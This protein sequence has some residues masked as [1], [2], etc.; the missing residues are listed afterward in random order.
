MTDRPAEPSRILIVRLSALGDLVFCTSLLDGLR[1]RF[2]DAHIAWLAQSGFAGVLHEDPRV[3]EVIAIPKD[4]LS[5]PSALLRLRHRL[6]ARRYDWVIDAQGLAK[7]RLLASLAGGHRI[8][9]RSK[10]P[11]EWLLHERIDKGG[12][13]ADIAS[14]YRFLAEMLTGVRAGPPQLPV[15]DR[16]AARVAAALRT[17]GLAPGFVAL[18]PFTTRPQK[19][20]PDTHWP[21]LAQALVAAGLG[22]CVVFGGP[23]E[24]A[25]AEQLVA[26][27][28]PG[29]VNLAGSTALPDLAAW[30]MQARL[31]VGV[32]T[33]LTHI[34]IAVRRPTVALFGSTCPYTGGADTPLAVLY[35]ALPCA[36]CKRRP[37][38]GG[39][40]TCM[41]QLTPERVVAAA[42]RLCETGT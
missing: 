10:E 11:L 24:R 17:H 6:H 36:P 23:A 42:L 22:P 38:C 32:D 40:W 9:F 33:G 1:R 28:P 12:N 3:D 4:T 35:D 16:A 2:P 37:T 13:P 18:C 39:A 31:V 20:W 26:Q 21:A 30:L 19:H 41:R 34:G 5:S 7:S 29:S 14:E 27:M 8:G 25:R 15:S